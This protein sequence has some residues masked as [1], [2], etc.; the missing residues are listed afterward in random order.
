MDG[1]RVSIA[2]RTYKYFKSRAIK[3]KVKTITVKRDSAGDFWIYST[4]DQEFG[5][6]EASPGNRVGLG[7]GLKCFLVK[8]DGTRIKSP[9][10]FKQAG[11]EIRKKSKKLSSKKRA[12]AAAK[13]PD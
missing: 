13:R 9:L 8:S 12:A 4:T 1:I 2:G 6:G 7:F 11:K 10:F 5:P 3:G